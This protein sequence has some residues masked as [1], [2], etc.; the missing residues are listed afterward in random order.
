MGD[1]GSDY[2]A[3]AI[4]RDKERP[5]RLIVEEAANEDNSVVCL[6]QAKMDE[7]QLFRG[8][9][10]LLK[11]KRRRETV[12]IVLSDDSASDNKIRINR[13]VRS[14]LRVRLG[15]IVSVQSCQDVKYGRRIHVLPIDDT[16]EGITGN[17]FEV[18]LKPYFLEAYRPV[19]KG[20]IFLVRGTMRAVEFKVIETDPSPYC[21]VAPDTIIHCEGKPVKREDEEEALN[22]VGYDD[23]GGCRKQLAAIKEMVELPLRHP[24]LFKAIGVKPPRGILMYGPPGTGKTLIARAV[25]NETGAFFFLINGPEVMSKLAGESESNLRKAFEQAEKNAPAIIFIDEIDAIAPKRE[26]THGEVER[27]IVSQLLTLMDGLKQRAHVVVMA[28]TNR[29][30]SIDPALRRFGRFDKEVDINVPDATGRLEILRIHTKNMKLA[31]NVDLEQIAQE[32]HGHVGADLASLCSEAALQQI[33]EKMDL[34][35]LEDDSIDAEVLDSLAVTMEDFRWALGKSNPSALR[36]TSI[37]VPSVTWDDIG[38]LDDVKRELQELVQYPVEHPEK[39]LKFGLTPS[40]GVL[41]YGP[42]GCGKTLLAKAIANECQ[43][44]FISIKGPELLT[45][46]FGESEANVRDIFDKAR[47]A[48]PCILFFDELDSIAKSRGGSVG[49]GGGASDRVIN[50]MLTEM[51]GMNAKKNVFIIG[52]TNRPEIIDAAILRPGRLDQLIYIPLPDGKSRSQILKANLRKSPVARDVDLECLAV[53]TK[54]FSGADLMEICQRACKLAI[55]ESI[56]A[57]IRLERERS[58]SAD[59]NMEV[60]VD[61]VPEIRK[62]HFERAMEPARRSVS[63]NDIRKYEMFAQNFQRS[64]GFGNFRFPGSSSTGGNNQP[65]GTGGSTPNTF[66]DDGEDD[67]YS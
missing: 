50:Q 11:G 8:D 28:A 30:N 64:R 7:L 51:D 45:M 43:A 66:A 29:P 3:T 57:E 60:D 49:D 18:Y 65:S 6:S 63:D 1:K 67:L 38:G 59:A 36:E 44:N 55:K 56:E 23:I 10:V 5:N 62:D 19:R 20:D 46:W 47:S 42:P 17:L 61:P 24:Q 14:N 37:E 32:T 34:I 21:I 31:D 52:A 53:N 12:V 16:V 2:L 41:F 25:A 35:D 4:L 9:T 15:D 39:F 58:Q 27:R 33:R 13:C 40:K 22:E 48:A 26:K 54:G